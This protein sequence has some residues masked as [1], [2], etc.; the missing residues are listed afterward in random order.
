[1]RHT[2]VAVLVFCIAAAA[3]AQQ[4]D[5]KPGVRITLGAGVGIV[6]R[7][8]GAEDYRLRALP[9]IGVS[10]GRFF[11]GGDAGGE[12]AGLG[13]NL[14]RDPN[15]RLGVA[16]APGFD[17]ARRESDHPS[18]QG[19]GDIDRATRAILFGGYTWRWL[20]AQLRLASDISGKDQGTL[21]F[22]DLTARY[23]A[24]E[25]L[26]LSAGPGV[27]WA[28]DDYMM[29]FFGVTPA[30]SAAS[31]L[32]AYDARAGLHAVR[33]A[34]GA[35]YRIDQR[36]NVFARLG[37]ARLVGDAEESPITRDRTQNLAAVFASYRF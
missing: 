37:T 29:T 17:R 33:F 11:A 4:E 9:I 2:A 20:S 26:T 5:E 32:P 18:L 25:R 34:V 24:S 35:S 10:Y 30:Q 19:L 13:F 21:A 22:F 31:T 14:V 36:W 23:P 7:Y 3:Q 8:P 28:S 27:T 15:W 12:G 6:P 1:M 16:L